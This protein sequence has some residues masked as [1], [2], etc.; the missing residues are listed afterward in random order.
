MN[1]NYFS[2]E[3][4]ELKELLQQYE[5]M[6][7]G[8]SHAFLDEDSF[9]M[10]IDYFDEQD[11][12]KDA[13]QAVEFGIE[14]FPFS[15]ALLLRKAELL[16]DMRKYQEALELL[17]RAEALDATNINLYI[18]KADAFLALDYHEQAAE[19]LETQVDNFTG[20]DKTDLLLEL[21]DVYDDWEEFEKVFE[22]LYKVLEHNN[23]SEEALHKIC[24]WTE[25]TGRYEESIRLHNKIID[26]YPYNE[27]AWFN[28][29]TA[30][31]GLKLYEKAIDAYLYA[32]AIDEKF[33]YAYRNMGEAYI[34][35]RQY[36]KAIETL[37]RHLEIA[38]P[39]DVIYEAMGHC[40]EKQKKY[41]EA[42]YYYRKAS[43]LSPNDDKLYFYISKNY[44][45]EE[46]WGNALKSILSAIRI[47]RNNAEYC[48]LA[49]ECMLQLENHK[50]AL[51]YFLNAIRIRPSSKK[52]WRAFIRGLYLAE[53]Y[54]EALAQLQIAEH[55]LGRHPVFR[56][57]EAAILMATGKRKEGL[58][59]L[60]NGL[61][62]A[63][64]QVKKLI[65]LNP[66]IL[67]NSAVVDLLAYY[68]KKK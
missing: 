3:F 43:H 20:E 21:S 23:N 22:C 49:G 50:E 39:E 40:Y 26:E 68:R 46:N 61:Q 60:E 24:F 66:S 2:E 7:A 53:F 32:I 11:E 6:K 28:L 13:F 1:E 14:Y 37:E 36:S 62:Q 48:L 8:R 5:N 51:I 52:N 19:I 35:L 25:F 47:N 59:Q 54:E 29:G 31:Q 44:M 34:R 64:R 10:I 30:Y 56:Y 27:L 55:S 38:K 15:A 65:E 9:E 18:L 16:I 42:R 67:Q 12:L 57:Y 63:P 33:E 45:M 58:I 17:A 41:A 4:D